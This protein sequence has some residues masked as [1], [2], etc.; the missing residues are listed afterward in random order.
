MAGL[1][2]A[3]GERH[4]AR[5]RRRSEIVTDACSVVVP[6]PRFFGPLP[7]R[8]ADDPEPATRQRRL[9]HHPRGHARGRPGRSAAAWRRCG[10]RG[11]RRT[12]RSRPR[13]GRWSCRRR[14]RRR[15]GTARR[16]TAASKSTRTVSANGPNA[17][18]CELV[19]PHQPLTAG[20]QRRRR[21]GPRSRRRRR[22]AAAPTRRRWPGAPRISADEVERDVVVGATLRRARPGRRCRPPEA[23]SKPS[24]SVCGNRAR[25][26]SIACSGRRSSVSVACTQAPSCDGER[27]VGEQV[28]EGAPEPGQRAG[29]RRLDELGAGDA[30]ARRGRPARSP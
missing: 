19:Q 14:W 20:D 13:R 2:E 3:A 7:G 10:R 12:A 22:R 27:R 1:V 28:V 8:G 4:P 25:S 5:R 17:V 11:R 26:R 15:A 29:D 6:V 18:I 24:T 30:V 21:R 16:R 9:E 23:G